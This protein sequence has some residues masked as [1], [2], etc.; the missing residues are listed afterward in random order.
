MDR[1]VWRATAHWVAKS[2]TQLSSK[3]GE[4]KNANTISK[5][6]QS[7]VP[8]L[9]NENANEGIVNQVL[10]GDNESEYH[11]TGEQFDSL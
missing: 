7:N 3:S 5:I 1:E 6:Q 10:N 4:H 11:I 8:R 2:Q 9:K